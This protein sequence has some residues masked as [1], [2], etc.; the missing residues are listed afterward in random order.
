MSARRVKVGHRF[1]EVPEAEVQKLE[2]A[3]RRLAA[4]KK[5]A[6]AASALL[7]S[8][9]KEMNREWQKATIDSDA[10]AQA[11]KAAVLGDEVA[12]RMK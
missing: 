12:E 3:A 11:A 8:L 4:L 7:D 9:H 1:I 6:A 2:G 5:K 10:W